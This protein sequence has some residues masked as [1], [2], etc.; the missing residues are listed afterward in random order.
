MNN[1]L[2][3]FRG[4]TFGTIAG[5][6]MWLA[7]IVLTL[8][9]AD[10][11][12]ADPRPT[13]APMRCSVPG[14]ETYPCIYREGPAKESES[15]DAIVSRQSKVSSRSELEPFQIYALIAAGALIVIWLVLHGWQRSLRSES[16]FLGYV[17]DT[18]QKNIDRDTKG[19]NQR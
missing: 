7:V 17:S 8:L 12:L 3:A 10:V 16:E 19:G 4:I 14:S 11:C 18:L 6:L 5:V 13:P 2:R 15:F 1:D 9:I